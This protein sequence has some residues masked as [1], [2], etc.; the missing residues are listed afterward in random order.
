MNIQELQNWV[1]QDWAT[2]N[3]DRPTVELQLLYIIE[4]M[5]EVAEAI[6]KG[7]NGKP[8]TDKQADLG[9][10]LAD[11]LISVITLSN[12]FDIDLSRELSLFQERM[13]TRHS[14]GL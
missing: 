3:R 11:L 10:E 13:K 2:G 6:R 14:A 1:E 7:Q 4:E 12:H 8:R 5:G 9:S